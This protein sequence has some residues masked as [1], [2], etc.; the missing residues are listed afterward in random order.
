MEGVVKPMK[1]QQE[2]REIVDKAVEQLR[3]AGLTTVVVSAAIVG[4]P[5]HLAIRGDQMTLVGL[6]RQ[7]DLA[8]E[9]C[10]AHSVGIDP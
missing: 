3:E 10:V 6:S 5:W 1:T 9:A 8:T 4:G 7:I 2:V